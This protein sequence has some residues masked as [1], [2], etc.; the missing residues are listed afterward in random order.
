MTSEELGARARQLALGQRRLRR[1]LDA[2]VTISADME[3]RAVLEHIVAAAAELVGAR[4]GALGVLGPE[5]DFVDLVTGGVDEERMLAADGLSQRHDLLIGPITER[6][7]LRV[8]DIRADPRS[9]GFPPCHPRTTT[10]LGVPLTVRDTVYGNLY[11]AERRT[12]RRS[13]TTTI[14]TALASAAS[15]SIE[16]ARLHQDSNG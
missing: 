7:P 1:L 8:D 11:L 6:K 2:V 14:P 10:L 16:N 15:V 13:P 12:A 3:P 5:R 4:Y 9:V